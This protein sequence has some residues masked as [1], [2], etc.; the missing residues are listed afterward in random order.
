MDDKIE[1]LSSRGSLPSRRAALK[2]TL[3]LGVSIALTDFA[4]AQGGAQG[5]APGNPKQ[6]R[7][8][9]GDVLVFATGEKKGQPIAPA[10]LEVGLPTMAFA[11]DPVSK[12]V[13]DGSRLNKIVL[14]RVEGEGLSD[15]ARERVAEGVLAYS[16]IC[17]HAGCDVSHWQAAKQALYCPCHSSY[18]DPKSDGQVVAGP[19]PRSLPSMALK[20]VDGVLV[21]ASGFSSRVGFQTT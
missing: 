15:K 21:A 6:L 7:P 10:D 9:Q 12:V 5:S 3:S 2:A 20:L 14:I 4:E 1:A 18:F 13:R 16:A 19:A 11:M 17:T 8:Q